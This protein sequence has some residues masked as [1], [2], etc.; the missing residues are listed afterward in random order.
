MKFFLS[1]LAAPLFLLSTAGCAQ[2]PLAPTTQASQ[3]V[4]SNTSGSFLYSTE[5][6]TEAEVIKAQQAWGDG[7]VRIG[8]AF[9]EGGDYRQAAVDHI[10]ATY[11]YDLSSVLFKPTLASVNQFRGSFD[12]AL[13]YFVGGNE[14]YP[15]DKGFAINPWTKV[16]W[17]NSGIINNSCTTAIAMGNYYFTPATGAEVKV[18]YVLGFVK[19]VNNDLRIVIHNSALPY[20]PDA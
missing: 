16:R 20:D 14:S 19:D 7:I 3:S 1:A 11:A 6:I 10:Q 2:G 13:S 9:T 17:E 4:V 8:K 18:E 15:E 5:C 12:G